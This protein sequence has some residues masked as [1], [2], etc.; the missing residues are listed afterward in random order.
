MDSFHWDKRNSLFEIPDRNIPGWSPGMEAEWIK[1][2]AEYENS[3]N[4][5]SMV[6]CWSCW[7]V[8]E[9]TRQALRSEVEFVFTRFLDNSHSG[10][11]RLYL[12]RL[13]IEGAGGKHVVHWFV[14]FME[15]LLVSIVVASAAT[16]ENGNDPQHKGTLTAHCTLLLKVTPVQQKSYCAT[17][18]N[19]LFV[20]TSWL[21][22]GIK[23]PTN[24]F[25]HSPPHFFP[26]QFET[27]TF[28]PLFLRENV[29]VIISK[30]EVVP[31]RLLHAKL[32]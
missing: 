20:V 30:S 14:W 19:I 4:V 15:L 31:L 11:N 1:Y 7:H 2:A 5:Y 26:L 21:Q 23:T 6:F 28:T 29:F 17:L 13:R 24:L 27:I 8:T 3:G 18:R 10:G 32:T 16:I 12:F 25:A 22:L 9:S